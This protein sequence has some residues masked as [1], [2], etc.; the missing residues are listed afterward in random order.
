MIRSRRSV[1]HWGDL[2]ETVVVEMLST[3]LAK[4]ADAGSLDSFG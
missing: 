1:S 4:A 2:S 3:L